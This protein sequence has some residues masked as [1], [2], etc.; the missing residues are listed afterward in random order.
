MRGQLLATERGLQFEIVGEAPVNLDWTELRNLYSQAQKTRKGEQLIV[1][2]VGNS[3]L[4]LVAMNV[5]E[6]EKSKLREIRDRLREQTELQKVALFSVS[7]G[8]GLYLGG[9]P[10]LANE[11]TGELILDRTVLKIDQQ[12][13]VAWSDCTGITV[14]G[15][16]VAKSKLKATLA[17][18]F[19][20]AVTAKGTMSQ[21]VITV[22]R[23]D[24]GLGF[25]QIDGKSEQEIKARILPLLMEIGVPLVEDFDTNIST[26]STNTNKISELVN[27]LRELGKLRDEGLLTDAEFA[28]EKVKF[29]AEME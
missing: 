19:L 29:I 10:E 23:R 24:G 15:G 16:Q 6:V 28:R 14:E 9:L 20:G 13:I 4:Y 22:R 11:R 1:D 5:S 3:N 17:F 18:G 8:K 27:G 12:V 25:L 26:E 7:L 2:I 21:T